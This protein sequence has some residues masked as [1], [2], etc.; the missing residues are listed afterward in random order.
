[1]TKGFRQARAAWGAAALGLIAVVVLAASA[2]GSSKAP[3]SAASSPTPP[4]SAITI[5]A[6]VSLSGYLASF[7]TPF[8]HGAEAAAVAINAQGGVLGHPL[9]IASLDVEST[10]STG[11][12]VSEEILSQD[13]PVGMI[14]GESSATTA[15]DAPVLASDHVA[16]IVGSIAVPNSQWTFSTLPTSVGASDLMI[17]YA[18][19]VLKA[20]SVGIITTET[21][22]GQ[23]L[24]TLLATDA[25]SSGMTVVA[26]EGVPTSPTSLTAEVSAV[27]SAGVILDGI[28]GPDVVL[29]A[30]AAASLG[31]SVPIVMDEDVTSILQ[32]SAAKYAN[33]VFT[34]AYVQVYPDVSNSAL[35]SSIK[36]FLT[37]Y[38]KQY[39]S[40]TTGD[41]YAAGRG[42]DAVQMF[43]LAMREAHSTNSADIQAKLLNMSYLGTQI[44]KFSPTQ[45]N[46]VSGSAA[47]VMAEVKNGKVVVVSTK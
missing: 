10:A 36:G 4:G 1:M 16:A 19:N 15:A 22:F 33:I 17:S 20:K 2:C 32:E 31:L 13:H 14:L 41:A 44:Y 7:D 38:D 12:S 3:S 29:E 25:T 23:A 40:D 26:S 37:T 6:A 11:L 47:N 45:L 46:G 43:A 24:A 34:G 39:G 27:A 9:Q 42:W 30:E 18:K 28:T 5:G 8:L 35:L 21:P